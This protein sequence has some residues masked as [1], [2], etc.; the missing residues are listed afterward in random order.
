MAEMALV[1]TARE[2]IVRVLLGRAAWRVVVGRITG[3]GG[4]S[5]RSLRQNQS[6]R[7]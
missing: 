1:T 2:D 5:H 6:I 3:A 7:P 4:S